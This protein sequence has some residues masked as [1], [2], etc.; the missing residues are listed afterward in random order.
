MTYPRAHLVDFV[1][2]GLYH[3][4]NRCVQQQ[5]LCGNDPLTGRCFEH[6]KRWIEDRLALL[7]NVFAV[8]L[9]AYAIMSNHYH[10]VLAIFPERA[11]AWSDSEVVERWLRL[12]PNL[13]PVARERLARA[14]LRNTEHVGVLRDRLGNLSWFMRE[15]NEH[16]A[17]RANRESGTMGRFWQGRFGSKSLLD[18]TATIGCMA[19]VDLNPVRAGIVKRPERAPYTSIRLRMRRTRSPGPRGPDL[20]PLSAL[21]LTLE[22]YRALLEWTAGVERGDPTSPEPAAGRA[23]DRLGHTPDD[24]LGRVRVHRFKYRAYGAL[25]LLR[26]YADSLGQRWLKGA[27]PGFAAPD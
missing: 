2:G 3:V 22:S 1:N 9:F 20:A 15:L 21:G 7:V 5:W 10:A 26:Q 12:R 6:R 25:D 8:D 11:R 18:D 19:Y 13:D 16:I 14:L 27:K 17:R 4:F 24:W 23:L